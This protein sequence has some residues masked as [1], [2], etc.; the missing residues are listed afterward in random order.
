MDHK[1]VHPFKGLIQPPS[2]PPAAEPLP[3]RVIASFQMPKLRSEEILRGDFEF[4]SHAVVNRL[5]RF[6]NWTVC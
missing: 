3:T 6:S 5:A 2:P 1:L 4:D